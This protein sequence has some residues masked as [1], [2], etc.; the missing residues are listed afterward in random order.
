MEAEL[1]DLNEKNA[2]VMSDLEEISVGLAE[3]EEQLDVEEERVETADGR[4]K[5]L[6]SEV[7]QVGNSLRSMELNEGMDRIYLDYLN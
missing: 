2:A 5:Q 3:L 4:V 1:A 6:E 7:T